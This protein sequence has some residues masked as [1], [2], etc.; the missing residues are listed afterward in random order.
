MVPLSNLLQE[1]S[2]FVNNRSV[3]MGTNITGLFWLMGGNPGHVK[4]N[5]NAC[6]GD[7]GVCVCVCLIL[8]PSFA[9][10]FQ[11]PT[12]LGLVTYFV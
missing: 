6:S 12:G 9:K 3:C 2:Y 4:V 5:K 8:S 11:K 1:A 7:N 10:H